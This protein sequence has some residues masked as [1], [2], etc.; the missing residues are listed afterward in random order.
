MITALFSHDDSLRSLKAAIVSDLSVIRHAIGGSEM[1]RAGEGLRRIA[2]ILDMAMLPVA[3]RFCEEIAELTLAADAAGDRVAMRQLAGRAVRALI[4]YLEA[5]AN[6]AGTHP[7]QFVSLWGEMARERGASPVFLHELC[8]FEIPSDHGDPLGPE[9][10]AEDDPAAR[11][12]RAHASYQ[13]GLLRWFQGS[14]DGL[15]TM[16]GALDV[17]LRSQPPS[18][19][20]PWW[21]AGA[22]LEGLEAAPTDCGAAIKKLCARVEQ[23][24]RRLRTGA[25]SSGS[26]LLC[27]L[28]HAIATLCPDTPRAREV[29]SWY[30][31]DKVFPDPSGPETDGGRAASPV[32]ATVLES[33]HSARDAL[34]RFHED[35]AGGLDEFIN[36]IWETRRRSAGLSSQLLSDLLEAVALRAGDCASDPP[37]H[38]SLDLAQ[39]LIIAEHAW[40]WPVL[41]ETMARSI[42]KGVDAWCGS[43]T[44]WSGHTIEI[45]TAMRMI[46]AAAPVATVVLNRLRQAQHI[47]G[48]LAH[49]ASSPTEIAAIAESLF[50]CASVFAVLGALRAQVLCSHCAARIVE[51]AA[52]D[53]VRN[54][55]SMADI[56]EGISGLDLYCTAL[57]HRLMDPER[58]LRAVLEHLGL[59]DPSDPQ[60]MSHQTSAGDGGD[61]RAS[62]SQAAPEL[63]SVFLEEAREVLRNIETALDTLRDDPSDPEALVVLQRGFH[64]LKGSSRMVHLDDLGH[65]AHIMEDALNATV[66]KSRSATT[67]LLTLLDLSHRRFGEWIGAIEKNPCTDLH[68][69]EL[70]ELADRIGAG[71]QASAGASSATAGS[72]ALEATGEVVIGDVVI[73]ASLF[74][75][76]ATEALVHYETL[77]RELDHLLTQDRSEIRPEFLRASHTLTG[78]SRTTG[79]SHIGDLAGALER[80]LHTLVQDPRPLTPSGREIMR[81]AIAGLG[82]AINAIRKRR[83]PEFSVLSH[84]AGVISRMDFLCAAVSGEAGSPGVEIGYDETPLAEPGMPSDCASH[85]PPPDA[86]SAPEHHSRIRLLMDSAQQLLSDWSSRR[87]AGKEG[88]ISAEITSE[89]PVTVA[90]TTLVPGDEGIAPETKVLHPD[91]PI[92][93]PDQT[94]AIDTEILTF[95]IEEASEFLSAIGSGL[96]DWRSNPSDA[97]AGRQLL[98]VLHNFKGSANTVGLSYLS[99]LAHEMEDEVESLVVGGNVE[100]AIFNA[101]E[102][103]FDRIAVATEGLQRSRLTQTEAQ[104]PGAHG[105]AQDR[106][107]SEPIAD[108]L[109]QTVEVTPLAARLSDPASAVGGA[110]APERQ[111]LL[112]IHAEVADRLVNQAGEISIARSRIETEMDTFKRGLS[113]LAVTNARVREQ[114]HEIAIQAESQLQSRLLQVQSDAT[115]FDPLEFDRYT[116]LQELTRMVSEGV[117]DVSTVQQGL[118]RTLEHTTTSLAEQ[119]RIDRE[120]HRD[121]MRLRAAPFNTIAERLYRAIRQAARESGK[122]VELAIRGG[123]VEINRTVLEKMIAPLEHVLRNAVVHGIEPAE[124]RRLAGKPEVGTVTVALR[125]EATEIRLTVS[126]DGAGLDMARIRSKALRLG[127]I[128]PEDPLLDEDL[129]QLIFSHGFSTAEEITGLSGRGVGMDIVMSELGAIGGRVKVSS[130]RGLGAYFSFFLPVTLGISRALLVRA[131]TDVFPIPTVLVGQ[132]LAG[133]GA[134]GQAGGLNESIEHLGRR[135][136]VHYLPTILGERDASCEGARASRL[137][138]LRAGDERVAILVDEVIGNQE[139]MVKDVGAQIGS[140]AGILGA[141]VLGDGRGVLI[142]NPIEFAR[143][144]AMRARPDAGGANQA[145]E[146]AKMPLV[147][148]VDD[149]LTVRKITSR[150][151]AREGFRVATARDG[152]DALEQVRIALPD[153]IL[154]DIE[155]PRMDGFELT[156]VLHSDPRTAGVPIIM[157]TSRTAEKHRQYALD[158]GVHAYL[159]KPYSELDLVANIAQCTERRAA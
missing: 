91:T 146:P 18:L 128:A 138:L 22:L 130:K 61:L 21:V 101:L 158:L 55:P 56:A 132:V 115:D 149:S 137:L 40:Q 109:T 156:R 111:T 8:A 36:H 27:D 154:L 114:L 89:G 108:S 54:G 33:L 147:L 126:D 123:H 96:R 80:W 90:P 97:G 144:G 25:P 100:T 6:G 62:R 34:E 60:Q 31:L 65:V 140:V 102:E 134:Y 85:D 7:R 145:A 38:L 59:P 30:G 124:V 73:S 129:M 98:R 20:A 24:L 2:G 99:R 14:M 41:S 112:R 86:A 104:H 63:V 119:K 44:A 120:H 153:V 84:N 88:D 135:Y 11:I 110:A 57:E 49:A 141:T 64:T 93:G 51:I 150:L 142:I 106:A 43:A 67:E 79:L 107:A 92:A 78:I 148:V 15:A 45:A 81:D 48:D 95:F 69:A 127:L 151:L 155:M 12:E 82:G 37:E 50:Q 29:S 75:T 70:L 39:A 103:R 26:P 5:V 46:D 113:D 42:A 32:H 4:D 118:M 58:P 77:K 117:S 105:D 13:R 133:R 157:V 53:S 71:A 121:L 94:E 143:R 116:R 23:E 28:L 72:A 47:L 87:N 66:N 131:G 122:K 76:F 17:V 35:R 136:N 68:Q 74:Q 9:T 159:G 16:R 52:A 139:I 19:R 152:I 1:G 125:P 83:C 10:R 3:Q